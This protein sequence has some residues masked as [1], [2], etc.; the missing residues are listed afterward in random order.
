MEWIVGAWLPSAGQLLIGAALILSLVLLVLIAIFAK[1]GS[2]WLQ[3]YMSGADVSLK[4]LFV[5][6]FLRIEHRLI[7]TAKVMGRQA[8]CCNHE[9]RPGSPRR[10]S[11]SSCNFIPLDACSRVTG[12]PRGKTLV[13]FRSGQ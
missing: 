5:M 7:V 8:G 12:L 13:R 4:S 3:A 6:S 10:E 9:F 1:W 11:E 2:F